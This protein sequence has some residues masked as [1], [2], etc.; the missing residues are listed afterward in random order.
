MLYPAEL[1]SL[2]CKLVFFTFIAVFYVSVIKIQL[3]DKQICLPSVY[4]Q[5][6]LSTGIKLWKAVRLKVRVT[7]F[8]TEEEP[9]PPLQSTFLPIL[10]PFSIEWVV[11]NVS[12]PICFKWLFL[13]FAYFGGQFSVT[14]V[15]RVHLSKTQII[16][17]ALW[18]C[19]SYKDAFFSIE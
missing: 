11:Y 2:V 13:R 17:V 7:G 4:I 16:I 8:F 12:P 9:K 14:W 3:R 1:S 6:L 15:S 10:V 19:D 5:R 18:G